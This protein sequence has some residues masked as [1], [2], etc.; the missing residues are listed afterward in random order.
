MKI[1]HQLLKALRYALQGL[2]ASLQHQLAFR[3][4]LILSLVLLPLAV[5]WGE[6]AVE[7]A[8][9]VM[10]WLLVLVAELLNSAIETTVD[11]IGRE[12]HG[13]SGRAKDIA[14]GAVLLS[15]VNACAVWALILW[16]K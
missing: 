2:W 4:E 3:L 11:R 16:G 9:L 1:V 13:L 7:R 15:L 10:S 8:L 5:Y 6:S 12:H 14:A